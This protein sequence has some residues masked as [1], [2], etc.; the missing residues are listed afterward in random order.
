MLKHLFTI[1]ISLLPFT[2]KAT[3]AEAA[4]SAPFKNALRTAITEKDD[5][6]LEALIYFEGAGPEDKQ[7]ITSMLRT[8]YFNGK[9]VEAIRFEPLPKDFESVLIVQGRKIE[10]TTQPKGMINVKFKGSENGQG[11]SSGPY[12]V[13]DGKFYLVGMKSIDLGWKGPPDKNIGFTVVG[14]GAAE[15]Q[16]SGVWNASG[17]ELRK[18]FKEKGIT[19][20]GQHFK[21]LNVTSVNDACDVTVTI[22]EDGKVVYSE[23]LKGKGV[24]QYRKKS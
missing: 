11:N 1:A 12:A 6:K 5:Q 18:E 2:S 13:V 7:R 16:I 21:E 22:T 19:F 20:W 15:L 14:Q 23:P 8:M 17:V 3:A 4:D 24:L 10:P 9:D